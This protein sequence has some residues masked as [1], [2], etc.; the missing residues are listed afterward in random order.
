MIA[1]K[2][3]LDQF[4]L[5]PVLVGLFFSTMSILEGKGIEGAKT[6]V[7]ASWSATLVK[8]WAL[9]GKRLYT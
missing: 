6:K 3:G 2:V 8:N 7:K 4:V 1:T 9:F 5:T